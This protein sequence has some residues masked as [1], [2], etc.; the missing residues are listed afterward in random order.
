MTTLQLMQQNLYLEC[1]EKIEEVLQQ[2]IDA[3]QLPENL[4]TRRVAV[5]MRG[6]ISG[7]MENWLFMPESFDL[8]AD[9]PQL[10]DTLIEMLIGCPTLRKP[11]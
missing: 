5:V 2:C 3:K 1:Y 10:V 9:A 7:I 11:A 4:N 6:Y 8:A